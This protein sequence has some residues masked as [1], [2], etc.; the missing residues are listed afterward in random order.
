MELSEYGELWIYEGGPGFQVDTPT[1]VVRDPERNTDYRLYVADVDGDGGKDLL[2]GMRLPVSGE[3]RLRFYWGRDHLPAFGAEADRTAAFPSPRHFQLADCDGD[4][5]ADLIAP[6]IVIWRSGAGKAARS[7]SWTDEDGDIRLL[8]ERNYLWAEVPF[9][10]VNSRRYAMVAGGA[11][12]G[13]MLGLSG[14]PD[15]PDGTYEALYTSGSDGLLGLVPPRQALGDVNGDGWDD[16]L[17]YTHAYPETA[18]AGAALIYAGG[19]YIPSDDPAVGVRTINVEGKQNAISI[20]PN[21]VN[22]VL[23]VAWRGDLDRMPRA[24]AIHDA[25]GRLVA[26]GEVEPGS[27]AARWT[28][29]TAPPGLYVL[30]IHE[31]SG[32]IIATEEFI[33]LR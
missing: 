14:G 13:V 26:K 12:G 23:N 28:C 4:G 16:V 19:P 20:W 30:S 22:D 10:Y 3:Q 32:S 9:G 31:S 18:E 29:D 17:C 8:H 24:F 15:G 27:P 5:A 11:L 6:G 21:P 1:V 7:R 2:T 25:S 33:I